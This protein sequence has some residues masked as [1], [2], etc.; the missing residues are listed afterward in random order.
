MKHLSPPKTSSCCSHHTAHRQ[1]PAA[2][3]VDKNAIYTC[4]MDPEI[5][6]V[7]PGTCPLCGM[8]LEPLIA[9]T[10]ED[11]S[12]LDNMMRRFGVSALLTLPLLLIMMGDFIPSFNLHQQI[13]MTALNWIQALLAT[14]V[15]LWGGW[16]FFVRAWSSFKNKHLNMFSLIGLGTGA[17]Y[18]FS[19]L[20]LIFPTALPDAFK[21]QGMLPLYFESAAVI[22][23]LVLLG[24]VLEL[25]A[26]SRTNTAIKSLLEWAPHTAL[27]LNADGNEQEVS[28][29]E[30][31]LGDILRVK[32]GAKVPVDGWV[33]EGQSYV[34]ESMI[35]GEPMPVAK[36]QGSKVTAGTINQTGSFLV[37]AEKLGE[38]TLLSQIVQMVSQAS[39]SRA[40]IQ[41]LT[42]QVSGWFVPVVITVAIM[43]FAVWAFAGPSP[44][45]AHALIVAVSVLIIACPCALGLATPISI[46]VGI[47]RG[48]QNGILIKD[49]ESLQ[50]MEKVNTLVVDKTGT[51]TEGKP[52][53][54]HVMTVG[55]VAQNELLSFAASLEKTSEHPLAS[56]IVSYAHE[57]NSPLK[58]VHHFESITGKG[59][60]GWVEGKFITLGNALLMQDQQI[61]IAEL[62]TK[63]Q[64]FRELGQTVIYLGIDKQLA[65]I[66]SVADPIKS[67]TAEALKQ[68]QK[69]G[70]RIV[71]LTGD[72][73]T[74][75]KAVAQELGLHEVRAEVLPQ[76]KFRHIQELQKQGQMVAMAGDGINDAPALAQAHVGIAMGNGTDIAINSA[77]I[78]LVKGDLR[79]IAKARTL[80]QDTMKNIRQNLFFAF[81]YNF[82]GVPIAAGV[83]YPWLGVLLSP[84]LASAAM[85]LS[86]VSVIANALR[87]RR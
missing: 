64:H 1:S 35:T 5:K 6:Q 21:M 73:S 48:A 65:G 49:A 28:L 50:L 69:T 30:I 29:N 13:S 72:N 37:R 57:K 86:S 32:P 23:T 45:L 22:V 15:V 62:E 74:T 55:H 83:L 58:E 38:N 80:S 10:Q 44:A 53:V 43:A 25:R 4:P 12:E 70:M 36:Q 34:D 54:Q 47:G 76:D 42:D 14:P 61:A 60:R 84:M 75:A 33:T 85:S 2:A 9:T 52:K 18:L 11:T 41:K 46:M 68:L 51:L 63:V 87:L 71:V 56:A 40:P 20:A 3:V 59:L 77:H 67:S 16:P 39:R 79:G 17:S 81:L 26:R 78:V 27:R 19:L 66:I 31:Q 7:G 8:A 24:Q 82:L